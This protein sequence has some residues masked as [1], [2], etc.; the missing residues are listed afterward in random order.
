MD[1][2]ASFTHL[3][4]NV[5]SWLSILETLS[6]QVA[7]QHAKFSKLNTRTEI[8]LALQKS[9]ST[10]SLRQKEKAATVETQANFTPPG[11]PT[12][13]PLPSTLQ[14]TTNDV[15][16][17]TEARRKRKPGSALSSASGPQKYRHRTMIIVYYNSDIQEAFELL[18]RNIAGARNNLRKGRTAANFKKRLASLDLGL[19]PFSTGGESGLDFKIARPTKNTSP[20]ADNDCAAFDV[21][22]KD[23]E[24]AQIL[25]ERAAHQMLREGDCKEEILGTKNSFQNSL[26]LAEQELDKFRA[27]EAEE[28]PDE[29]PT[30]TPVQ[31]DTEIKIA[32]T[33]VKPIEF[34][35]IGSIEVDDRSDVESFHIDLSAIRRTRRV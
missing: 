3:T 28:A 29:P 15:L 8:K 21:I 26:K 32:A 31:I 23:L 16:A 18:V 24:N 27:E 2:Q 19:P 13:Y 5:P 11:P 25:C 7:E 6:A 35:G 1:A 20:E 12:S 30:Q 9:S 17:V 14:D 4:E 34:A 22:D 10:E 33:S